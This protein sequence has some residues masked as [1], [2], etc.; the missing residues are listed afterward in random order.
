VVGYPIFLRKQMQGQR[1]PGA[2][3]ALA[4]GGVKQKNV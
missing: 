4:G 2:N 1:L 3:S